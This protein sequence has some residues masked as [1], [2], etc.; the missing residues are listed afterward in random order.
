M[1]YVN[2]EFINKLSGGVVRIF[3]NTTTSTAGVQR[4]LDR[5]IQDRLL[6]FP[7]PDSSHSML[8]FDF[9]SIRLL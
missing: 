2:I 6:S 3:T 8:E 4:A 7:S 1:K 9:S 5:L